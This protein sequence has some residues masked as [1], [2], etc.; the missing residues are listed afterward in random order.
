MLSVHSTTSLPR[1]ITCYFVCSI[2]H[3][4]PVDSNLLPDG[5]VSSYGVAVVPSN[6]VET[7]V[8][9]QTPVRIIFN[10]LSCDEPC[11]SSSELVP[12]EPSIESIDG[13]DIAMNEP[14]VLGD[15]SFHLPIVK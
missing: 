6:L 10:R 3:P 14:V 5:D 4:G 11:L 7:D 12:D 13:G 9:L 2:F 15:G 1:S 8:V